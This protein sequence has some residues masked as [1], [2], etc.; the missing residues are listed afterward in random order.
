MAAERVPLSESEFISQ[1]VADGVHADTAKFVWV[2]ASYYYFEALTPY[3][4]DRWEGTI[5]VDSEDL[6]DITAKFWKQQG[7]IEPS[8]KDPVILPS[9]PTLLE[10]GQWLDRSGSFK[11]D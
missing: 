8:P 4:D 7:W 3:P 6:E 1:L 10:F 9:N 2:E 11:N 5:H